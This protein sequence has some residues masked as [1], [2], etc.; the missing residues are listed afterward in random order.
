MKLFDRL[1][2]RPAPLEAA[3]DSDVMVVEPPAPRRHLVDS[4]TRTFWAPGDAAAAT[5]VET[6]GHGEIPGQRVRQLLARD[7]P[8]RSGRP[9]GNPAFAEAVFVE[10]MRARRYQRAFDQLA[11]ECQRA[12]GGWGEFAA[13]Q[14]HG[15]M[16]FLQGV[17]VR[18]VRPVTEW[19]DPASGV[20]HAHAVELDADYTLDNG[21]RRQV[22]R[23]TVHLVGVE[24]KWHSLCY[25]MRDP[26]EA[27]E[28]VTV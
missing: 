24:G 13:A 17:E 22:I 19:R 4:H 25:P 3:D 28:A 1:R 21:R 2:R 6:D 7:Q 23:R 14:S 9:R 26:V 8:V 18:E 5:L 20:V 12:W 11:P 10:L 15:A 27:S 16:R